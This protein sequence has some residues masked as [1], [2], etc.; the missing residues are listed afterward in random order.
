MIFGFV[1]R[2]LTGEAMDIPRRIAAGGGSGEFPRPFDEWL[3]DLQTVISAAERAGFE[4]MAFSQTQSLLVMARCA[5]IPTKLRFVNETLT[6][7]ML[8]PVQLAPAAAYVDQM[9]EGRLDLG[10]SIGYK[11][12]DLR[13][14]GIMR[15]DRVPKFVESIEI[16][17]RMWTQEKVEFHG[18]YFD[19]EGVEPLAHPYQKP[20]PRIIVSTQAH[21][22]A[23]RAGRTADGICIAPPVVHADAAALAETFRGSYQEANGKAP[24]YVNARRDFFVGPSPKEAAAQARQKEKYLQ[25]GP[26]HDYIRGRMQEKTMVKLSLDP[27]ADDVTEHAFSG[28]YEDMAEQLGR[29]LEHTKL[30]HMTCSFYNLSDSLEERMEFLEGFGR[31]VIGKFR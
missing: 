1:P 11:P 2:R 24:G 10:V 23:A 18:E 15:K 9:L 26:E 30:T 28:T 25:F 6:L 31:E 19:F 14:A 16:I 8:D 21:G 27:S 12:W 4:Y 3:E 7:P 17:K 29:M 22:S 20:R 13:A 5:S